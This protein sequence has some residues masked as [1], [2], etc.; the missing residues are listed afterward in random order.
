M[1]P[2]YFTDEEMRKAHGDNGYCGSCGWHALYNEHNY[3]RTENVS[4]VEFW[5][6]C[7]NSDY[8][9]EAED[10]RGCY[11]YPVAEKD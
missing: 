4:L 11:I 7:K 9:E 8:P 5:D 6:S 2:E 1:K 10:H 3:E